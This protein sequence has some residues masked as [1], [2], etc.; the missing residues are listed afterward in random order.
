M[1]KVSGSDS[2]MTADING[3]SWGYAQCMAGRDKK[4]FTCVHTHHGMFPIGRKQY[5]SGGRHQGTKDSVWNGEH[6]HVETMGIIPNEL[7]SYIIRDE[8]NEWYI[9]ENHQIAENV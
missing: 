8:F 9:S 7:G 6:Y 5:P 3:H 2:A 1:H 4:F